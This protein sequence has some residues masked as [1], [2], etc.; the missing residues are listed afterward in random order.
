MNHGE[1][2]LVAIVEEGIVE[3]QLW[4]IDIYRCFSLCSFGI[5]TFIVWVR[6]ISHVNHELAG[7][8]LDFIVHLLVQLLEVDA[9][10]VGLPQNELL[11]NRPL[12]VLDLVALYLV[13]IFRTAIRSLLL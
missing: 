11:L 2:G 4:H 8:S 6:V 10:H 9:V 12:R 7:V 1:H 5:F 3:V 13:Q